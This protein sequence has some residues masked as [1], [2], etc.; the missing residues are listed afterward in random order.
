MYQY[1]LT[2]IYINVYIYIY[3]IGRSLHF[4]SVPASVLAVTITSSYIVQ[5]QVVLII[6]NS[7]DKTEC[8]K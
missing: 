2:H 1:T 6:H 7:D 5:V 3:I 4:D 8:E